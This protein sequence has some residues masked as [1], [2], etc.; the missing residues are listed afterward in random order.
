M[1]NI[2]LIRRNVNR[3]ALETVIHKLSDCYTVHEACP[4]EPDDNVVT[5]ELD[6]KVDEFVKF[7][8]QK[9][10]D[11]CIMVCHSGN[12]LMRLFQ[13]RFIPTHG[14]YIIEHDL[15]SEV[16]E[17]IVRAKHLMAVAFTKPHFEYY[18]KEGY[19]THKARWYKF[20][21]HV[22]AKADYDSAMIV[23]TKAYLGVDT[24]DYKH[25]FKQVYLKPRRAYLTDDLENDCIVTYRKYGDTQALFDLGKHCGFWFT[26]S[27]SAF[28][29]AL[30]L[31]RI[32]I[33]W[34]NKE[35]DT[36]NKVNEILNIISFEGRAFGTEGRK[37]H[38]I[39]ADD[40]LS[41]KV[42][43]LKQSHILREETINIMRQEWVYDN[44]LPS[45]SE[46]LL[47]DMQKHLGA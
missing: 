18:T 39:V 29:E 43:L 13:S 15:F 47:K 6:R 2:L 7:A 40:D 32:P 42:K 45:V 38:A 20:D 26:H 4:I 10:I 34:R 33:I 19:N 28:V 3:R 17:P 25:L 35:Y 27:S 30:L 16:P 24:F 12:R 41:K 36:I 14:Y 8:E 5:E 11:F 44:K 37:F 9:E 46:V 21:C 31:K 23:A 1:K 22:P